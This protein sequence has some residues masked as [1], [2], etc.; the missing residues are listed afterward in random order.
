MASVRYR[1][2]EGWLF[3]LY[4]VLAGVERFVVEI[5]HAKDDRF[6]GP[7]TT[8]QAI[9]GGFVVAGAVLMWRRRVAGPGRPG[10]L[11]RSTAAA[12]QSA[13]APTM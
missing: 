8:A 11:A 12:T 9:S 13:R 10:I 5:Y 4:C 2:A 3:G 1:H 7:F 6:L